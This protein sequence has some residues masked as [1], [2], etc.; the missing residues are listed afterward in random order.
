MNISWLK[1]RAKEKLRSDWGG[2]IIACILPIIPTVV[3]QVPIQIIS[4][5]V[6]FSHPDAPPSFF[7]GYFMAIYL[8]ALVLF[9]LVLP[10]M[11]F[12]LITFFLGFA[13]GQKESAIDATKSGLQ[14]YK[15]VVLTYIVVYW[16]SFF[17]SLLLVIPG[18]I[19][20]Y[21]YSMTMYVLN[22]NP[23]M[24][25]NEAITE[26]RRLMAGHKMDLFILQ[27]SFIGWAIASVFTAYIGFLFLMPYINLSIALFY[28]E[29]TAGQNEQSNQGKQQIMSGGY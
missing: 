11:Q 6:G 18:I 2:P 19:K 16:Y 9:T 23:E 22:D 20:R 8:I 29:I 5:A 4:F 26:S 1:D 24:S 14:Y 27:L 12:G 17:W 25:I 10:P 3:I 15:K 13:R 28:E 21:S 7:T